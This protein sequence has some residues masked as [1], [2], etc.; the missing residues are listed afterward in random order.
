M[1][2]SPLTSVV[3][4]VDHVGIAVPDLDAAIALANDTVFGLGANAWTNSEEER[5]RFIP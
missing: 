5:A 3:T 4:A 2:T 1:T